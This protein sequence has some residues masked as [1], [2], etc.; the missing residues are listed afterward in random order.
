MF[1]FLVIVTVLVLVGFLTVAAMR[2]EYSHFS[3][4]ELS[5]R[6]KASKEYAYELDR[7]K[8]LGDIETFLRTIS[9]ILFLAVV[10]L[11]IVTFGWLA[12]V[13]AAVFLAILYPALARIKLIKTPALRLYDAW[14][15]R[16]L[17]IVA[18]LHGLLE[19][20]H[21]AP[22]YGPEQYR[23]FDSRDELA[24]LIE[25][26]RDVLSDDERKLM[27]TALAFKSKTVE[28]VMTP[29]NV[30]DFIKKEE[31]LGPLVLSELSALGHSR[32]PVVD[33]DLNQVVGILH[34]RDMLSLDNK[35]SVTAE[36]AMEAKVY[37]I[38]HNDTLE[39]AL[40]AF[41]KTR[42]HLFVVINDQRETVGIITLEDVIETLIGRRIVDEDDI[43]ADLRAVATQEGKKNNSVAEHVDL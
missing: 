24:E 20:L 17:K 35:R 28:S 29:R 2:P 22:F 1:T 25:N 13:I 33:K 40:A 9:A 39:H 7:Q 6:A 3:V 43:H 5:R 41:L 18:K 12:G 27:S 10:L 4:S 38:H 8:R 26:S 31:F 37:Y 30:V 34:L 14:E 15:P 16:L 36:K 19:F 42:H 32:L 23:R 21:D 11:L